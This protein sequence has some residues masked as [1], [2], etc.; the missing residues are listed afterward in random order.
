MER[1][2]SERTYLLLEF[3]RNT[4][5]NDLM[6]IVVIVFACAGASAAGSPLFLPS[7]Q[8]SDAKLADVDAFLAL[9]PNS[10]Y[11]Q[12]GELMVVELNV[13]ELAVAVN[14]CQA[15]IGFDGL[16]AELVGLAEGGL[17]WDDLIYWLQPAAGNLDLAVGVGLYHGGPF[18]T[19]D[20]GT[21]AVMTFL[22]NPFAT[23][24]ITGVWFREDVSDIEST[25][26]ADTAAD[27][28]FPEKADTPPIVVDGTPPDL[29]ILS[30]RQD[31]I[32]LAQPGAVAVQAT[33][34]ILVAATDA[35][36]GLDGMPAVEIGLS[37]GS[38]S[39]IPGIDNGDGT[40]TYY[41][42]IEPAASGGTATVTASA[43]DRCRNSSTDS[44]EFTIVSGTL[45]LNAQDTLVRPGQEFD[46]LL[47]V[48]RLERPVNGC[49]AIIGH[50][51]VLSVVDVQTG[52]SPWNDLIYRATPGAGSL[53]LAAGLGFAEGEATSSAD[54]GTV[55]VIKVR[56]D[57]AAEDGTTTLWFRPDVSDVESTLLADISARPIAPL[58]IGSQTITIDA[59]P[60]LVDVA[61]A[62]QGT[63]ELIGTGTAALR[64]VVTI[65]VAASDAFSGLD[66]IP[67]VTLTFADGT[68]SPGLAGYDSGNGTFTYACVITGATPNGT[69]TITALATDMAGNTAAATDEIAINK[70]ELMVRVELDSLS[71][72]PS[73]LTRAVTFVATGG[74]RRVWQIDFI[75]GQGA[76]TASTILTGVPDGT[77]GLSAKTEWNLRRKLPV[78]LGTSGFDNIYFTGSAMLPGGDIDGSNDTALPDY[79]LLKQ[80]WLTL[81]PEGDA[82]DINGD[83]MVSIPDYNILVKNWFRI[84]DSE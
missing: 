79:T 7:Q 24:G 68:I 67:F 34:E 9:V 35:T 62:M 4:V 54:D 5:V 36:A 39:A 60:P 3:E 31:G 29:A 72:G 75:F 42:E 78:D 69:A 27:P 30:V 63:A 81:S 61:S 20:D 32:D 56:V 10:V 23:D 59:T 8:Q 50:E 52:G 19:I 15:V 80:N 73:G 76:C 16:V 84:G 65:T 33:V 28:V 82:A 21:V 40:F 66:G 17:P 77:T 51:G 43:I 44:A 57:S 71:P 49:Q 26:L 64:G 53:D 12:P 11:L 18:S 38:T 47:D 13:S 41:Y 25:M 55:A 1:A 46:V 37:D 48:S 22:I 45:I 83:G 70:N 6:R 2:S 58:K 14:G 74:T